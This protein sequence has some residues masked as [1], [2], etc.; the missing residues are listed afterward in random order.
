MTDGVFTLE[1]LR[2]AARELDSRKL[3]EVYA[4][5]SWPFGIRA[6][7]MAP[8]PMPRSAS[9]RKRKRRRYNRTAWS[10]SG[11]IIMRGCP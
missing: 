4:L 1:K 5:M 3:P 7:G 6:Y 10:K 8:G 2:A 9:A 11:W